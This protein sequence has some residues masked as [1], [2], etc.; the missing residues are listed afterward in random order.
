MEYH[1]LKR[2]QMKMGFNI[3]PDTPKMQEAIK[4]VETTINVKGEEGSYNSFR[5][6][7]CRIYL[8]AWC[9]Q[10]IHFDMN[11]LQAASEFMYHTSKIHHYFELQETVYSLGSFYGHILHLHF[12]GE[13][14]QASL[15]EMLPYYHI[16]TIPDLMSLEPVRSVEVAYEGK[17][18]S[19]LLN[20]F[21]AINNLFKAQV[22]IDPISQNR[23]C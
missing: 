2:N 7:L 20:Q 19:S 13:W 3:I 11:G 16:L 14:S 18:E 8:S 6:E 23:I 22:G 21:K 17:A 1:Y 10:E 4:G 9:D 15:S 5:A 12:N